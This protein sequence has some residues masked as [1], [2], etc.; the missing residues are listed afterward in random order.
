[1]ELHYVDWAITAR[2]NLRCEHCITGFQE[3]LPFGSACK[4]AEEI[5]ELDPGWVIVEGG[6]PLMRKGLREILEKMKPLDLYLITN[7]ML[8]TE[9]WIRVLKEIDVK[10]IFSVDGS[11]KH[12]YEDTKKGASFERLV[13]AIEL[14]SSGGLFHGITVVLSKKNIHQIEEFIKFVAQ[15]D[16]KF[17]TFIPLQ[18]LG[19]GGFQEKYYETNALSSEEHAHALLDSYEKAKEYPVQVYYDEPFLWAFAERKNIEIPKERSGITIPDLEGCGCGTSL[20]VQPG[21]EILPCM[22][23]PEAILVSKYP[24]ESLEQ[25]W[26]RVRNS[27]LIKTFK[28]R[29]HRRG[30]CSRCGYFDRCYGCF[31]RIYRLYGDISESDPV[32][33]LAMGNSSENIGVTG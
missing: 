16:G 27:K 28:S 5:V 25:G 29:E 24:E 12:V 26:E 3:E 2:C 19:D 11:T 21:G 33:P 7:G 15:H 9:R 1:M 13:H 31:S 17:I 8:L 6:E 30:S 32:C 22:F 10:I 18:P 20:Y 14:A 23:C 4:L